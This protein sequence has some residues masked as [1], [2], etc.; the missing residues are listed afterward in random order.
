MITL[1]LLFVTLLEPTMSFRDDDI[2]NKEI[3]NNICGARC[4]AYVLKQY[5][6]KVSLSDVIVAIHGSDPSSMANFDDLQRVLLKNDI[7]CS[8]YE[9]TDL[10]SLSIQLPAIC[11]LSK[12][13]ND[14]NP[15]F[16]VLVD[17]NDRLFRIWD[18]IDGQLDIGIDNFYRI[19]TGKILVTS[20][21]F[22]SDLISTITNGVGYYLISLF[23]I[24]IL[25]AVVLFFSRS[26]ILLFRSCSRYFTFLNRRTP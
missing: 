26:R 11:Q 24:L 12:W 10:N 16:V 5:Q 15:H 19:Y 6:K 21:S 9:C 3:Y 17:Y 2:V 23:S 20:D 14:K 18:G 22:G 4:V 13:G 7:R 1:S 8:G 25:F